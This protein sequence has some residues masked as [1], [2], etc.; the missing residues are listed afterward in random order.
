LKENPVESAGRQANPS[1]A[2]AADGKLES[3]EQ[4]FFTPGFTSGRRN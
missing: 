1:A 3:P 4:D 2:R